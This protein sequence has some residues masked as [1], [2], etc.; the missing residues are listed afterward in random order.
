MGIDPDEVWAE[1]DRRETVLGMVEK[2]PKLRP[3]D[4]MLKAV[5]PDLAEVDD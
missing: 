3:E 1:M 4:A 5:E 2:L